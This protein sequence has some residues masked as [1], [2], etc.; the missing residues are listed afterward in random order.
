MYVR[1]PYRG[2]RVAILRV[3]SLPGCSVCASGFTAPR[4]G[5]SKTEG[6]PSD[7]LVAAPAV[8][9]LLPMMSITLLIYKYI[10]NLSINLRPNTRGELSCRPRPFSSSEGNW[11]PDGAWRHPLQTSVFYTAN[12]HFLMVYTA[13]H[14]RSQRERSAT[15]Y[16]FSCVPC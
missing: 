8:C 9:A 7:N 10:H 3:S 14:R 6:N 12:G 4:G 16:V 11:S 2:V 13:R 1:V 5:L 15:E